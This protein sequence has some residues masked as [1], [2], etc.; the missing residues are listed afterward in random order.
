[1]GWWSIGNSEIMGDGPA[2]TSAEMFSRL[3]AA[4]RD[5]LKPPM[6]YEDLSLVL[7]AASGRSGREVMA[8]PDTKFVGLT[9]TFADGSE[10]RIELVD[11]TKNAPPEEVAIL[12]EWAK[13]VAV[14]YRDI[15]DHI[16]RR[17]PTMRELLDSAAFILR[18]VP[19]K[20]LAED[21]LRELR[22]FTARYEHASGQLT[23]E[24]VTG[25]IAAAI[26]RNERRLGLLVENGASMQPDNVIATT[27]DGRSIDVTVEKGQ[28]P[29][30]LVDEMCDRF[31]AIIRVHRDEQPET[32]VKALS[33]QDRERYQRNVDAKGLP[34]L[35][36]LVEETRQRLGAMPER[37]TPLKALKVVTSDRSSF[38]LPSKPI[39]TKFIDS[40]VRVRHGKFGEGFVERTFEDG[41]KKYEV[42]FDNGKR[43]TLL[44]RFL[45][46]ISGEATEK[47]TEPTGEASSPFPKAPA[48]KRYPPEPTPPRQEAAA[49]EEPAASESTDE[50]EEAEE[51]ANQ[52]ATA[53][54]EA[55][56]PPPSEEEEASEEEAPTKE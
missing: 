33:Q 25:I 46:E 13:Q 23:G 29:R 2:D 20:F 43:I 24:E 30:E 6:K 10:I 32:Y 8:R 31:D 9:T 21:E 45:E 26:R 37:W 5:A 28:G 50:D 16:G 36:K 49:E 54:E 15:A 42:V 7:A 51:P 18:P 47:P 4:R 12:R 48:P 35:E 17:R 1:M 38:G 19:N 11:A 14:H 41:D 44:A 3:A 52:A 22:G 40:R 34:T 39:P 56:P 53:V 27:E 55:A